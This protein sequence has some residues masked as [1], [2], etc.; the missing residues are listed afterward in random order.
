[1]SSVWMAT[2][3]SCKIQLSESMQ[4]ITDLNI[5]CHLYVLHWEAMDFLK[6]PRSDGDEHYMF[7][8]HTIG[9]LN[10]IAENEAKLE[11]WVQKSLN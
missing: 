10:W 6:S 2:H 11:Q 3:S 1:M 4:P 9:L 5:R 8:N 7:V